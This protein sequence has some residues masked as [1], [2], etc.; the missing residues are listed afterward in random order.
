MKTTKNQRKVNISQKEQKNFP[1]EEKELSSQKE[2]IYLEGEPHVEDSGEEEIMNPSLE[3]EQKEETPETKIFMPRVNYL[4]EKIS[5]MKCDDKLIKNIKKGLGTQVENLE[6]QIG[7]KSI[8][9]P[10][11]PKDIKTYIERSN[12]TQDKIIKYSN[13]DYEV[14]KKHK[15][16]K[17][18]KEEQSLLKIKLNKIEENEKLLN[19]EGFMNL[20][21]SSE[22]L[23]KFDKSLKEQQAKLN[24][25][26]K[27]EIK[28]RLKEIDFRIEQMLEKE[29]TNYKLNKQQRLDNYLETYEKDKEIIEERARRYLKETKNKQKLIA[30]EN[31]HLEEEIKKKFEEEEK[32]KQKMIKEFMEKE[33]AIHQKRLKEQEKKILE[34][35]PYIYAKYTKTENDYLFGKY[36]KNYKE[37]EEKLIMKVNDDRKMKN[38]SVTKEELEDFLVD[39]D[40]KKVELK[41]KKEKR[42]EEELKKFEMAKNYKPT[43]V[44]K[45][46]EMS[47]N[48]VINYLD[49][50][51][52]KK[53]EIMLLRNLKIEYAKKAN[54]KYII[55]ENLKK[56]RI[57]RIVAIENPNLIQ[58][59]DTLKRKEKTNHLKLLEKEKN[60]PSW[61][62]KYAKKLKKMNNSAV[63][64]DKLIKKPK[65][66]FSLNFSAEK[67][68]DKKDDKDTKNKKGKENYK[69]I[70]KI[71]YLNE[72]RLKRQ[73]GLLTSGDD[74]N[75]EK[76]KS[77]D[78][79][80][81]S[82]KEEGNIIENVYN[83][84][85]KA[86][87]LE[88]KAK[89]EEQLLKYNG[90]IKNNPETGKKVSGYLIDSIKAKLSILNKIYKDEKV[91][92]DEKD[93]VDKKDRRD[94][95][96]KGNKNDK[97]EKENK[98]DKKDNGDKKY[99]EEKENKEEYEENKDKENKE[100]YEENQDKEFQEEYKENQDKEFQEEYKENQDKEFQEEYKENQDKEFQEEY[101]VNQN[102]EFKEKYEEKDEKENKEE[103][104]ENQVNEFKE[105]YKE[106]QDQEFKEE[107]K[108]NQDKEFKEEY[109]EKL[110]KEKEEEYEIKEEKANKGEFED[111][112]Y[113]EE[114]ED[115]EYNII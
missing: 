82:N 41:L 87:L 105:K 6:S 79:E 55:N 98:I 70:I 109:E 51:K 67:E 34:Y 56:E 65:K 63:F 46:N 108:E 93:K 71:D 110:D 68:E 78:M 26:K 66:I 84:Q 23:T 60:K 86:I 94:K 103:Y 91:Q 25:N 101:K 88:N 44:S 15:I 97:E 90:G 19:S 18:L 7:A 20:N 14:K 53:D 3:K 29:K 17:D 49:K 69:P 28:E 104:K 27:N 48:E 45:Y 24:K 75:N 54:K 114:N 21:N 76:K 33:K 2:Q 77:N 32:K 112:E 40:K 106:N 42:D 80:K 111:K 81:V 31:K 10:E 52:N 50:E 115:K 16:M 8:I 13:E 100:E 57:E 96:D 61:F 85:Q 5:N 47:N 9:I 11:V 39:I 59:K 22:G 1:I 36:D 83:I 43:Y 107:Y 99:I 102:K 4:N 37:K 92:G 12:S 89:R 113:N 95:G 72:I 38:K 35:K 62:D 73:K 74:E 30:K 64:E 58:I